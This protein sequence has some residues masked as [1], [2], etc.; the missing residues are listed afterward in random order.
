MRL[1]LDTHTLLWWLDEDP[2]LQE[3]A[4]DAIRDPTSFVAVSAAS[5]WE[6]SIKEATGRLKVPR[7]LVQQVVDEGF[8]PLPID[9]RHA[10]VAGALPLH[11]RDPF[12]RMLVAQ[13]QLEGLTIVTRDPQIP[14]YGVAVLAA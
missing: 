12:D 3:D 6:A 11:H 9:L 10:R 8:E 1:L 4:Q 5:V 2:E 13:A 7:D 14:S